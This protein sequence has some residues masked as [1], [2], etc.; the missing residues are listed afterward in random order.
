MEITPSKN[1][2]W[3]LQCNGQNAT[4]STKNNNAIINSVSYWD[5]LQVS[6]CFG[7]FPQ[8]PMGSINWEFAGVTH[9]NIVTLMRSAL[10]HFTITCI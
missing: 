6:F 4:T 1:I 5:F 8:H 10:L 7:I 9:L 2:S 3:F